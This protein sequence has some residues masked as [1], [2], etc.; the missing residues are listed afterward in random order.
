MQISSLNSL[1]V[2]EVVMTDGD[3]ESKIIVFHDAV[4]DRVIPVGQ[5]DN[6]TRIKIEDYISK[7]Q[8]Q[9]LSMDVSIPDY[10]QE[11]IKNIQSGNLEYF[12]ITKNLQENQDTNKEEE[13]GS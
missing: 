6:N 7:N 12:G 2:Y 13:H 11:N 4:N 9:Q 10:I 8:D 1:L 5:I 3:Q